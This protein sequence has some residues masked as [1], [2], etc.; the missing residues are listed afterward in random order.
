MPDTPYPVGGGK[1]QAA[2][3]PQQTSV[4]VENVTSLKGLI[5]KIESQ[6]SYRIS[7]QGNLAD[8]VPVKI[9]KSTK[10]V[11]QLLDEALRGTGIT[12]IIRQN[13][14]ILTRTAAQNPAPAAPATAPAAPQKH[15]IAGQVLDAAT[16]Q[17][18]IGGTV[19]IKD[20]ALGTS[21]ASDG[22]F[23]Y[24]FTGNFGFV[25]ISYVGYQTQEFPIDRIPKV[26][27]LSPDNNLEEVVVVGYGAQKK[28][29]VIGSIA[30]VP[31]NDI[32]MPTGKISNNL[33]GQLAGVIS[34]QRSGEPGASSTF[35]IRGISTFGSNKTPLILVDGIERD[36]DLV[37]IE[38]I[39]EFSILKDAAATAVY[40]VRG[41]NGVVLIT[42]R[43]GTIG[44]PQINIK[45]EAG[46]VQPTKIPDMIDAVQF[47][48]MYN[49]AAG[50]DFYSRKDIQM[51][52]DGSD[53]DLHP[54]IDW[55]KRLYKDY[56]FNQRVN[57]NIS[58][59]GSTAKYYISGGFY[60]E[61]GLFKADNMKEY[62]TSV[63]YRRFNFRSN[64]EVQLHKYTKLNVNLATTFERKNEP[65]SSTAGNT[66]KCCLIR[67]PA[68]TASGA[69]RSRP[70]PTPSRT[71]IRTA[72]W[73]ARHRDRAR[74]P[75]RC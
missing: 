13:N 57:V 20:S 5:Q 60:N 53:P 68:P 45:F 32:K 35:W 72:T 52:R 62:N 66:I 49:A 40:G 38:D 7:Y 67:P 28:A 71:S 8:N 63:F 34:V 27:S 9:A 54:N 61:D 25:T 19:W 36:L 56:S 2:P 30:S 15:H 3:S 48:E 16:R 31:V 12:Y 69:M 73:P 11:S 17:P 10:S 51:F 70:Q 21:T 14:I 42:T 43:E 39:K 47:A 4:R 58:G 1:T 33:A 65:G 26:I 74:T 18:I 46:M 55:V 37:D 59:G 29:S 64:V 44:K 24:S 22:S 75:M 23:D 41:A 50:Y 6:T